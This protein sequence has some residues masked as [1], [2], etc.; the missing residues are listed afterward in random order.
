[1]P[2]HR[3]GV[4]QL[5]YFLD[6]LA[7]VEHRAVG[8]GHV[9]D[10]LGVV[11]GDARTDVDQ[12]AALQLRHHDR[13]DGGD[14][15][16]DERDRGQCVPATVPGLLRDSRFR[17]DQHRFRRR[18]DDGGLGR[19]AD[20]NRGLRRDSLQLFPASPPLLF[21]RVARP[22]ELAR[23]VPRRE[24]G[25]ADRLVQGGVRDLPGAV[26][27]LAKRRIPGPRAQ[28]GQLRGKHLGGRLPVAHRSPWLSDP[29]VGPV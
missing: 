14:E 28:R 27:H 2:G 19:I 1:M 12:A 17:A 8:H 22:D 26:G 13:A 3:A 18:F 15:H 24:P 7:D 23:G 6:G 25:A 4:A 21:V 10:E 16:D 29:L 20:G 5:P 9:V 11:A